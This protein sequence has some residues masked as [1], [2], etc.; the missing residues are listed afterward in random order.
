MTWSGDVC[1]CGV[2]STGA[3]VLQS[4]SLEIARDYLR[5]RVGATRLRGRALHAVGTPIERLTRV[6]AAKSQTHYL[7][8]ELIA[9]TCTQSRGSAKHSITSRAKFQVKGAG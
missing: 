9:L 2:G 8:L 4:Q 3:Q 7:D 1:T 5:S 6:P